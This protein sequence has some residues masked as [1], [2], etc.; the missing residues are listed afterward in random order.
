[1]DQKLGAPPPFWGGE[2]GHTSNTK[3]P[4]PR[5]ISVPSGILTHPAIWPQQIWADFFFGGG[6]LCPFMEGGAGCPSNTMWPVPTPTCVPSF[7]LI[8]PTVWRQYTNVTDK[9][10]Q[11]RQTDGTRS[12][13][14][15]R[16]VLQTAPKNEKV[17]DGAKNRTLLTCGN[18]E[19]FTGGTNAVAT[20]V[21]LWSLK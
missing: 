11:D 2:L 19:L 4:G 5:S 15:G 21:V 7:I 17:T 13:S 18:N 12:D 10:G 16:T 6:G 3:S 14:I 20:F 9:T 1:M 8:H